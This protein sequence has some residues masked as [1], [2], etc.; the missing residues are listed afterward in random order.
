MMTYTPKIANR[1][2]FV[3]L[4]TSLVL[5]L[6]FSIFFNTMTVL[7]H[8]LAIVRNP[9]FE[10]VELSCREGYTTLNNKKV[11]FSL[12]QNIAGV[13]FFWTIIT[14]QAFRVAHHNS[15]STILE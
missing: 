3:L 5:A 15:S 14:Y 7:V 1:D 9:D 2:K 4:F 11:G 12:L 6:F 10:T 8:V 13:L